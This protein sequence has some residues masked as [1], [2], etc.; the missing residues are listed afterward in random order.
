MLI[1][2]VIS[3]AKDE[4]EGL[5]NM[6]ASFN[7]EEYEDSVLAC[8]DGF[9]DN[10]T[11]ENITIDDAMEALFSILKEKGIAPK[12]VVDFSFEIPSCGR[13]FEHDHNDNEGFEDV[14]FTVSFTTTK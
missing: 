3:L 13:T 1:T 9:I 2:T 10:R 7:Y 14:E 8:V 6:K 5:L 11:S 12:D 4:L